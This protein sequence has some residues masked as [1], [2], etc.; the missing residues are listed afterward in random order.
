MFKK[1]FISLILAVLQ[2]LF[3]SSEHKK[4]VLDERKL[5]GLCISFSSKME[6]GQYFVKWKGFFSH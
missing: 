6:E 4:K 3:S 5:V 2:H 1:S